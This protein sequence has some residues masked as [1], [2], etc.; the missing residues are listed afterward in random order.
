MRR[1]MLRG[2]LVAALTA[3]ALAL[4]GCAG[5][6]TAGP[7][8]AGLA[9]GDVSPPD[10]SYV[11]V[12]PQPGASPE[13][14]VQGFIDAGI[15]PDG[16]WAIAQLYLA[17]SFRTTWSPIETTTIDDRSARSYVATGDGHVV[18]TVTQQATVDG[19]GVYRAS[20]GGQT[21]LPFDLSKI[22]GQWRITKAPD[23]IVLGA[24]QFPSV[25]HQYPLMY[26]D[27]TWSFLVPDIRYFPSSNAATRIA[28]ALVDGKPST[29][30][31][32]SVNSA[33][34]DTVSLAAQTVS[35]SG[36]VGHVSLTRPV[37]SVDSQTLDRMQTQLV[38]S[39]AAAGVSDVTMEYNG[40]AVSAQPVSTRR[41]RIDTRPLVATAKGFGFLAGTDA[42][43]D[44]VKG[45]SAAMKNV[46]PV[47][48]QL[49]ADY[50][51]AA[52]RTTSGAVVR[53]PAS[54]DIAVLDQ[55]PGLVDPDIDPDGYIWSVP[56]DDPGALVAYAPDG[57]AIPIEGA[58]SN[59]SR[60]VAFAISRDGTRIAAIVTVGGISTIEVSGIVRDGH[61]PASLG[62]SVT[63]GTLPAP[64]VALTWLGDAMLGA[65]VGAGDD[66]LVVRQTVVGPA[67]STMAPENATM[68]S[69]TLATTVRLLGDDGTLYSQRGSNWEKAGVGVRMLAQAQG[70]PPSQG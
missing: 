42:A 43:V 68:I 65:L 47:A 12:K 23:G 36:G 51:A 59:A 46:T 24:D 66:T 70:I 11:P 34:A 49:A 32:D 9:P 31:A 64:G 16:N 13:Q 30:L 45:I 48:V 2:G 19:D 6:P 41:T 44:P 10:F 21:P 28:T 52:V 60:V 38:R 67:T 55:R 53:V 35:V 18:L 29:W 7:V 50:S 17:P 15:G 40:S 39:M 54:G 69:G 61:A 26:F 37:L 57:T 58:W 8:F 22:D 20:D 1:R 25:F 33:F 62:E 27:P 56:A 63:L 5:L 14:I 3:V 4:S